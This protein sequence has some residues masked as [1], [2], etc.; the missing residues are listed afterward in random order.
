MNNFWQRT[1]TGIF[2]VIIIVGS[3]VYHPV[4]FICVFSLVVLGGVYELKYIFGEV[5]VNLAI[6]PSVCLALFG[7]LSIFLI[8]YNILDL[9]VLYGIIPL[10]SFVF[11]QEL[12]RKKDNPLKNIAATLF[13]AIY[14]GVPFALL[15]VLAF[16]GDSGVYNFHLPLSVFILVWVNDTGAYLAGVTMGK[17]KFFERISPKKTWEGTIGG[18]LLAILGAYVLS[19]FWKD[20]TSF[21]WLGFGGII[22]V[23][24]ILGDLVESMFKRSVGVKD[25][26]TIL[27]G[28][29]GVL[30]RFDAVIFAIPM[31][32]F[33][34]KIIVY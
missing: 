30:D 21:T 10:I 6:I 31:A 32:V 33:Y 16:T 9:N 7:F 15:G 28:H 25:S 8:Q 26:G 23:M 5:N 29:G 34:S 24:A 3:I 19:L 13:S 22:S 12:F 1:L 14:I 11:I 27:P 20:M 4:A 18:F 17:T 2:F